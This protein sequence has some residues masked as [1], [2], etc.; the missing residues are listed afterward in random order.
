MEGVG[1]KEKIKRK[2]GKSSPFISKSCDENETHLIPLDE[3]LA[4]LQ[5]F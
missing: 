5:Y 1:E 4:F 2:I 3:F